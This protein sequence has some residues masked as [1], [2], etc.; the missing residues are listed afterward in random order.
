MGRFA[1]EA[2]ED[3]LARSNKTN[4]VAIMR[5][6]GMVLNYIKIGSDRYERAIGLSHAHEDIYQYLIASENAAHSEW[7]ENSWRLMQN[8]PAHG[9]DIVA[10]LNNRIQTGTLSFK[11]SC[12]RTFPK[13]SKREW[14]LGASPF[15]SSSWRF[16]RFCRATGSSKS[17]QFKL[18]TRQARTPELGVALNNPI[19]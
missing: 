8:H 9:K 18:K 19:K 2:A 13:L 3:Y 11:R 7:S 17:C 1:F 5:G 16:R 15:L 12:N 4:C 10:S 14:S 6:T